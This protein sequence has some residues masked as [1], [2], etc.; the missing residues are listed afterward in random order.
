MA[1]NTPQ[2]KSYQ[3][4][5]TS[6]KQTFVAKSGVND[7][8]TGSAV[9]SIIEAAALNDFRSQGNIIAVLNSNDIDR[10]ENSDLDNI[11][12]G[13]G[14]PRPQAIASIGYVTIT[15]T[16][17]KKVFTKI[18]AGTAA[19]PIG[20]TTINISSNVGFPASGSVYLGRGS[21][22]VEGPLQY[23][24]ITPVGNYFQMNLIN[25]TVK[26]HN[27]NESVILAQG[28]NRN[29][30]AGIIVQTQANATN[31]S[32]QFSILNNT[33]LPNGEDTLTDVQVVCTQL[34]T[35]GN[36]AAGAIAQFSSPPFPGA[37]VTN[38]TPFV[39]GRDQMS[40]I[41]YRLL[42]KNSVQTRTKG[43]P[44]AITTAAVGVT[45]TDDNKTVTSAQILAPSNRSEPAILYVDDGT[46]YEPI[47]TGQG[48]ETVI[49]SAN[50]GEQF[51][52]L[53]HEDITKALVESSF[54][55]PFSV[56]GSYVLALIVGG[57]RS[58]H[59]FS[60][61]D[62]TVQNS[63]TT[64]EVVNSINANTNLLFSA[65]A[66]NSDTQIVLFAKS[67][68]NE[69][70]Q[71]TTPADTLAIDANQFF[72]FT[73]T[74]TYSLRLYKNDVL[75]IKD[76][77]I[78]SILTKSQGEW[79]IITSPKTLS[80]Q[81]DQQ[82][83][84][85]TYTFTD[86]NFVPFGV[87]TMSQ[88]VSLAIWANVFNSIIPGI[89]A[90]VQGNQLEIASNKGANNNAALEILGGTLQSL[91][92]STSAAIIDDGKTSDY[93]LNRATGQVELTVPL[94][95]NDVVTAGSKNTRGFVLS[96]AITG[97]TINL[98]AAVP[99]TSAGPE[100]WVMLDD[101]TAQIIGNTSNAGTQITITNPSSNTWRF[102]SSS[103]GSFI[104]VRMNDWVVI[105]DDAIYAL[106]PNFIGQF[107][108]E[109]VDISGNYFDIRLSTSLG[110][111][112]GPVTL[113]GNN[114]INFI[115]S[116]FGTIQPLILLSGLQTITAQ[117]NNINTEIEGG[118]ASLQA[119]K[120][121]KINTNTYGLNG[122]VLICGFTTAANLLGY[123]AGQEDGSFV[124]HTA[125][126]ESVSSDHDMPQFVHDLVATGNATAPYASFTSTLTLNTQNVTDNDL[127]SFLN[128][129]N[130]EESSNKN[131]YT[132]IELL[133][134]TTVDIRPEIRLKDIIAAD[135]YA[136]LNPYD[137]DAKDT[138]VVIMD[139]DSV[140][141]AFV[142][143]LSRR[144]VIA[145][146]SSQN[147]VTAFDA[148]AG[149][150]ANYPDQ[151]GDN[152]DFKDFKVVFNAR[153]VV[154]PSGPNNEFLI[155]S[156]AF[157]SNGEQ[158]RFAIDYPTTPNSP[159][160]STVLNRKFT[161]IKVFLSSGAQRSGGTW[162]ATTQF[163]VTNTA[164]NTWRYNY[165]GSGTNPNFTSAGI[166]AGDVVYIAPQSNFN[167]NN[168]GAYVVTTV[169]NVYFEVTNYHGIS[170]NNIELTSPSDLT[171]Y[172][173]ASANN[174]A[175]LLGT[176][177]NNNL[178]QYITIDQ[179]ESGAGV[180][181]TSTNDDS[182]GAI[183]Y[184]PLLDGTNAILSSNIGTTS[185]PVDSFTFKDNLQI[186]NAT[187]NYSLV[188]ESF[189]LIPTR[190]EQ[191]VRFLN[192]FAVTG[193]SSFANIS[194]S[195]DGG[196]LQISSMT[197]GSAGSVEIPGGTA[198]DSN[199]A[200]ITSSSLVAQDIIRANYGISITGSTVTVETDETHGLSIGDTVII[201][202][203][204][205]PLFDGTHIVT[206]ITARTFDYT[207]SYTYPTITTA[208]RALAQVTYTTAAAHGLSPN[209]KVTIAG[210]ADTSFNGTYVVLTVLSPTTFT[211]STPIGDPAIAASPIGAVRASNVVTLTTVSPHNITTGDSI[212]VSG[213]TDSSFDGTFTVTS[214][215]TTTTL[216]YSQTASD[217]TSG[218]GSISSV[219]TTGGAINSISSNN[220]DVSLPYA[221]FDISAANAVGFH[222][223]QWIKI[224]NEN[225]IA[226]SI[227]LAPTS[228]IA[229]S[230]SLGIGTVTLTSPG[231]FQTLR[232][233]SGN[234][235]TGM[236]VEKQGLFVCF[237]WDLN[238]T[239]PNFPGGGVIEGDWVKIQGNFNP[240]NQGI[241]P[242]IK[243]FE[244]NTF[245]LYNPNFIEEE[246]TLSGNTDL[247]FYSYDSVLPGD[248]F[249]IASNILGNS[250]IGS[251]IVAST[252]FPTSN[253]FNIIGAF[254][255]PIIATTLGLQF[256]T[257]GIQSSRVFF[258][259]R[260]IKNFSPDPSNAN[261]YTI[262]LDTDTM[263]TYVSPEAG[264]S[265]QT[266]SK[267]DF[268]TTLQSGQDSYKYYGGLI[269][270]VGKVIRGEAED[271]VNYPG[272]AA[273]GSYIEISSPLPRE[274]F[275]SIVVR[276]LTGIPF[277]TIQSRVQSSV[278]S[279]I[280]SLG[281]GESVAFS[282]IV[283]VV[284][285][286]NGIQ[287]LAIS[288]PSYDQAHLQIIINQN[289][290][291]T[292]SNLS[293]ITVSLSS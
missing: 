197:F 29:I 13:E 78:P 180:I 38:P 288:A 201:D 136:V 258:T 144:G 268:P 101:T 149:P 179:L 239:A 95:A 163:D 167:A 90:T 188:G 281:I 172:P 117:A 122:A 263:G 110:M 140:N 176:Y 96:A 128:P 199:A 26:N 178:S 217:A 64:D 32:V 244:T 236:K 216:Q 274:V 202:G 121:L 63:A 41:D 152:F 58:E 160:T 290:K 115:R 170:E 278:A 119:G 194:T 162:D 169:T 131:V 111:S 246:I 21:N 265:I 22:N 185:V 146:V 124:S 102:T 187:P 228:Q 107:R 287:A 277:T 186:S 129:Y 272:V 83:A 267:F 141:K 227:G 257:I 291:A 223:G 289:E 242:V 238:G 39:T 59:V 116:E 73:T 253:S 192:I 23:S 85:I 293:N 1:G 37:A 106:D 79:S 82:L 114:K 53:Q 77:H 81:L 75:L 137:F 47:F 108:V 286:I 235:T 182:A 132:Q 173:L 27:I 212:V 283:S 240:A 133:N 276:N 264:G 80:V 14:V 31:N 7:L 171:F 214:T 105:S 251:Y 241:Y 189:Y 226:K 196:K 94:I 98:P 210:V 70:V 218:S 46:A 254:P 15:Q 237:S 255:A 30:S 35:V 205:N 87:S 68:V 92:F 222:A 148:D 270:A 103:I 266:V 134:G 76:G 72:G 138:L 262:I 190:A 34:G 243:M 184:I 206:A 147:Q 91:M 168:I 292:V 221:E 20:S 150:T 10:A 275:I 156:A 145:S 204:S 230:N 155:R 158:I 135:R 6:M 220:G 104:N 40:D 113:S 142:V 153:E 54:S 284:Q 139:G 109:A 183:T 151:F 195:T 48:F 181:S 259:W 120:Y 219:S 229:L 123:T 245:Y 99:G 44:L 273:A 125:F 49:D 74:L 203:V 56:T 126:A 143:P 28:G 24:S 88:T 256:F 261:A 249:K 60:S 282:E 45:S 18:Y 3:D 5:V 231:T 61:T 93:A 247:I 209:D 65:R 234:N 62:F 12:F 260:Q 193:L 177:V 166:I 164:G 175:N 159:I 130:N 112:G 89:T 225:T 224:S 118:M 161:D 43:T 11:G 50:G 207:L 84:P 100:I 280:Q 271:P 57:V 33:V 279:Y 16:T 4:L 97:G 52:Q 86:A 71:V 215:P 8:N 269:H 2:P 157:G 232:T 127:I 250:N 252:P 154:D 66:A 285:Q 191:L 36:V 67:Y 233:H 19:P 200:V 211:V 198:N 208:T 69:D 165:N 9:N 25:P 42:I 248:T 213:V 174:T 55:A 51:L 17:I